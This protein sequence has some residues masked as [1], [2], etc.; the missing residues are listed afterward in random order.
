MKS[1]IIFIDSGYL[2]FISK[3]FGGG[4]P[5]KYRIEIFGKNLAKVKKFRCKKIYFYTAP[6]YQS[7][8]PTLE[9]KRRKANYD[10]FILKL[11]EAGI[12]IREG[13]CQKIGNTYQQKG[14]D[15]LMTID[16]SRIPKKESINEVI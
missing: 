6:P 16:L 13:R 10:K 1:T 15:T 9:E 14:V 4:R 7:F 8:Q 5:L 3:F 2:S 12:I 11:K